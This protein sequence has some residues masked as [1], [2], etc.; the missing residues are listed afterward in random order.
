V[1]ICPKFE[2]ENLS[3][4]ILAEK[5]FCKIDPWLARLS[6]SGRIGRRRQSRHGVVDV[7]VE[8]LVDDEVVLDDV[9][10]FDVV[11]QAGVKVGAE[12][13]KLAP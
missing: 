11:R 2:G 9:L 7:D 1:E 6:K 8:D 12:V 5:E 13:A 4:K 3:K 10:R